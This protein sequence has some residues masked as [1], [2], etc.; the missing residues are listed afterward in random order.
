MNDK[1]PHAAR[2]GKCGERGQNNSLS[3]VEAME[4]CIASTRLGMWVGA[5]VSTLAAPRHRVELMSLIASA[6]LSRWS[7]AGAMLCQPQVE[8]SGTWGRRRDGWIMSLVEAMLLRR[9]SQVA[10]IISPLRGSDW[11]RCRPPQAPLRSARG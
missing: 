11:R 9:Y 5:S 2:Q 8:R 4:A 1:S 6:R 7:A 3:L 10:E